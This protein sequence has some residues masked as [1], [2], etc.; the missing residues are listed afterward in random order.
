MSFFV[1]IAKK[2]SHLFLFQTREHGI[3]LDW[4]MFCFHNWHD[5]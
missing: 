4:W 1:Q 5:E 2:K 3:K